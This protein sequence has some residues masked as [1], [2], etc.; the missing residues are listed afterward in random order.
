MPKEEVT[1]KL[2]AILSADV[3]GYSLLMADDEAFTVKTLKFY[4][5]VMSAQIVRYKG[6]VVDTP[7]DNLLSEF[8]SVVDAVQCAVEIQKILKVK[9]EDLSS[10]KRLEFRIGVNIGDVIQDGDSIYGAGVNVAARIEGL[11]DAGGVCISRNAYDHVKD[12]LSFGYEY[13]G[14]HEVKNI[15]DPVRVYKVLMNPEDAGKLIGDV[16]TPAT[17]KWVWA[18]GVLALIVIISVVWQVYQKMTEPEFEP[19]R[20]EEMAFPLPEKPSIAVLPFK[21][22]NDDSSQ[23][24]IAVGITENIISALSNI[25]DMFVIAS[26][27]TLTYKGKPVKIQHVSEELSVR[28]VL[29]GS[30]QK[31]GNRV[32]V[33]AKLIDATTGHYLWSEKYDRELHDIFALQDEI[34]HKIIVEL[35]VKLTEGEQARVSQKSTTNLEAWNYANR[36]LAFWLRT[37]K[38]NNA[39]AMKLF[40]KAVELDPNYVWAWV[41]LA[42]THVMAAKPGWS[43]SPSEHRKKVFEISKNVLILDESDS[44]VHALLGLS[45]L[46]QGEYDKAITE[47]E[48]SLVLGPTNAQA[49]VLLAVSMNAV[50]R[51]DDVIR[52]VKKAMRLHPYYPAY[53]LQW[54]G[55]AYRMTGRYED[56]LI[57]YNQLLDRSR[58]G[59]YPI[60]AAHLF[61][62]D[63]YS[64]FGK[65]NEARTHT[66]EIIKIEPRFSLEGISKVS[67]YGYKDPVHLERRLKALRK[68]GIPDKPPLTIHDKPSI[69]VLPFDNLSEDPEQGYLADGMTDELIGD[70]AKIDRIFVISRNSVFT[71]KGKAINIQ[72]VAKELNVQYVLEG[73]IQRSGSKVRIRAQL[74]DGKTDHHL[75]AES[76]D[77]VMDDIFYLQ[78][79]ISNEIISALKVKLDTGGIEQSKEKETHD[80]RAYEYFLKG[81]NHYLLTTKNDFLKAIELFHKALEMDPDYNRVYAALALVYWEGVIQSSG[82]WLDSLDDHSGVVNKN[83]VMAQKYLNRSLKDPTP[84]AYAISS[85]L[86][87]DKRKY[88]EAKSQAQ[89]G[90]SLNQSNLSAR[91]SLVDALIF[92]GQ[93]EQALSQIEEIL[94]LDPINPARAYIALSLAYYCMDNLQKAY[95]YIEKAKNHNPMI[96]CDIRAVI[97]ANKGMKDEALTAA[98]ACQPPFW[99]NIRWRMMSFQF[100]DKV[101]AQKVAD[102]LYSA[103]VPG[104]ASGYYKIFDEYKLNGDE[105]R[106]LLFNKKIQTHSYR[107]DKMF[108]SFLDNNVCTYTGPKP[109]EKG[110]YWI[111]KDSIW[112]DMPLLFYGEKCQAEVYR[113]PDESGEVFGPY[114]LESSFNVFPFSI[115][116]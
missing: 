53:Y 112:L 69:A 19:A 50:G 49:H 27:S 5:K 18:T 46:M 15:K 91:F 97:Y 88:K 2:R 96:G 77:G 57:A 79:K 14:E 13:L 110:A 54:L 104:K 56:A 83:V 113:Y 48:K 29:E 115:L 23:D 109:T 52:L 58:N 73:S 60:I 68:A 36:G 9:N 6:R 101:L 7:G 8:A 102:G 38:E 106:N 84:I 98:V 67:T 89:K 105:I 87:L 24:Y 64:E 78:D 81:W 71:Y 92:S 34:T 111:E 93:P 3:K 12:K 32:R 55:G 4:R 40:E 30:A 47:G 51:F 74:I 21:N 42:W 114:F 39:K 26:G 59:E 37:S 35:Q 20:I 43:S 103:G 108:L 44:D 63:L 1:R 28:Y 86:L 41:K 16:P 62:A 75:W 11:A 66:A 82:D 65:E 33:N 61:L 94:W 100:N 72:Q 85:R 22:L 95:E 31:F 76:Y 45:Y 25:S 107:G 90:I 116:E 99:D 70:L 10:D 80:I 17:K